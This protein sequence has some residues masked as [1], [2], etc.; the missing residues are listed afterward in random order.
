MSGLVVGRAAYLVVVT[1][2]APISVATRS[3]VHKQGPITVDTTG[4]TGG[5]R[6]EVTAD[7][8][9]GLLGP[10]GAWH[11]MDKPLDAGTLLVDM[12]LVMPDGE[13][14]PV[15]WNGE[16]TLEVVTDG[17]T[18]P[19]PIWPDAIDREV[20]RSELP[21][22]RTW[23]RASSGTAPLGVTW[24]S[25]TGT[26]SW[27]QTGNHVNDATNPPVVGGS[28]AYNNDYYPHPLGLFA[29][30]WVSPGQVA[31][32][33]KGDSNFAN[34]DQYTYHERAY[35]KRYPYFRCCSAGQG[36][37]SWTSPNVLE[38]MRGYS[39]ADIADGT[40]NLGSDLAGNLAMLREGISNLR[41]AGVGKILV[42]TLPPST[43]STDDWATYVN[44]HPFEDI[45]QTFTNYRGFNDAIRAM[46]ASSG[47]TNGDAVF[48]ATSYVET[49][50]NGIYTE[51]G[52][53]WRIGTAPGYPTPARF[54]TGPHYEDRGMA[55]VAPGETAALERFIDDGETGF[56][57]TNP[58]M[59]T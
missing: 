5:H 41:A 44:Q 34:S 10:W 18:V 7:S 54:G 31:I 50:V 20:F 46:A 37:T 28:P 48:N 17:S 26:E 25:D 6:V 53:Y 35:A 8:A 39:H 19:L 42:C 51:N 14:V 40:N 33:G 52:G 29:Q 36:L 12:N 24:Y 32:F 2:T 22:F 47:G 13:L 15:T 16:T 3:G 56:V 1:T 57:Q 9:Q 49:D 30:E 45:A 59:G 43:S 55:N 38:L 23:A 11:W 4:I 27:F 21:A 58:A